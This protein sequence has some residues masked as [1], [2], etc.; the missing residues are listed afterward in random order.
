MDQIKKENHQRITHVGDVPEHAAKRGNIL[1]QLRQSAGF[2]QT[3]LAQKT[4]CHLYSIQRYEAGLS[5]P[6]DEKLKTLASLF[7]VSPAYLEGWITKDESD[8]LMVFRKSVQHGI[9]RAHS[10]AIAE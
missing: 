5:K 3:Q 10:P 7:S 9:N 8:L 2:T 4:K 1:R 6:S